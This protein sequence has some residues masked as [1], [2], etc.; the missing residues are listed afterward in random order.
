[1]KLQSQDERHQLVLTLS[2]QGGGGKITSFKAYCM[3][4][5]VSNAES[6]S[7]GCSKCD[8]QTHLR[9]DDYYNPHHWCRNKVLGLF[10]LQTMAP[11]PM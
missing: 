3:F 8:R 6:L 5:Q 11:D 1:M 10:S 4:M 2:M 9:H 7:H